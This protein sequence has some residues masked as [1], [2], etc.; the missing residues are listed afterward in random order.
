MAEIINRVRKCVTS[1]ANKIVN[2]MTVSKSTATM[3][4]LN[5]IVFI[6]TWMHKSKL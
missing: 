2:N 4:V 5:L 1:F 3:R 6:I